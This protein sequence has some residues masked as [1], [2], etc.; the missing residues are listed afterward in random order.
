MALNLLRRLAARAAVPVFI[1]GGAGQDEAV[2]QLRLDP[3]IRVVESPRHAMVL[4]VVGAIDE[5]L[6][7]PLQR[8][9]DALPTPRAALWWRGSL[10][11]PVPAIAVAADDDVVA[12]CVQ[13]GRDL[14][15]GAQSSAATLLPDVQRHPWRGVGPYGQGGTGMTGGTPYG[16]P[17]AGR[18][19]DLRDRLTL[20]V[21]AV[22][23]GPFFAA[24]PAGLVL[25]VTFQGDIVHELEVVRPPVAGDVDDLFATATTQPVSLRGLETERAAVHLRQVAEGLRLLGLPA[26]SQRALRMSVKPEAQGLRGFTRVLTR[27][28]A[29]VL[30]GVAVLPLHRIDGQGLGWVARASGSAE[31]A[32]SEDPVYHSL[33]FEPITQSAGD[34]WARWR[35]RLAEAEQSI[36]LA[37][38]AGDA[39]IGGRGRPVEGPRGVEGTDS[40]A[41]LLAL[42]PEWLRGCEWGDAVVAMSSLDL[43]AGVGRTA[44]GVPA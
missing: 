43:A 35:Q 23:V 27:L 39:V 33:G 19:D 40:V 37:Q 1:V 42:L 21:V 28:V 9:A 25:R 17:L 22:T 14:V 6:S 15:A 26:L 41:P 34:V 4:L 31:D 36:A 29:P 11:P 24:L 3:R 13:Q 7:E 44:P 8:L 18:A 12:A 5:A 16:R 20:D 10:P 30:R 38:R 2:A 32:R